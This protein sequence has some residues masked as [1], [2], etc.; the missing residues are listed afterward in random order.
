M[1]EE[2]TCG[3]YH[4][5]GQ[6][7]ALHDSELGVDTFELLANISG[8]GSLAHILDEAIEI[9]DALDSVLNALNKVCVELLAAPLNTVLDGA[10]EV[11][12]RAEWDRFLFL[13]LTVTVGLG[14]AWDNHL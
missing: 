12:K 14:H 10:W 11:P 9:L 2:V 8:A 5:P 13:I 4:A 7:F 3:Q 1:I 6:V